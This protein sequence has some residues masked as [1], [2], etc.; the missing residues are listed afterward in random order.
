MRRRRVKV[1]VKGEVKSN[2]IRFEVTIK[3]PA[4]FGI[5]RKIR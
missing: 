2:W 4:C 1:R 5:L 3:K